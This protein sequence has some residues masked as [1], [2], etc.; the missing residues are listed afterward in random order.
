MKTKLSSCHP[1]AK[2]E[3]KARWDGWLNPLSP[4]DKTLLSWEI[5]FQNENIPT[6]LINTT[7]NNQPAVIL[8]IF[9]KW[10]VP[11]KKKRKKMK[12]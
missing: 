11:I 12:G 6:R 1:E 10:W 4:E 5:H 8:E 9:R 7:H 3:K 2:Q